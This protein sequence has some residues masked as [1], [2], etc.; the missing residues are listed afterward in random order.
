LPGT[1]AAGAAAE[2]QSHCNSCGI[3]V[4]DI[5]RIRCA[6]CEDVDLCADCF[7]EGKE[8]D[9]HA[10]DHPYRV[11]VRSAFPAPAR[12]LGYRLT[13]VWAGPTRTCWTIPCWTRRG[14]RTRS[15]GC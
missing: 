1:S 3:D 12:L 11:V 15:C 9:G 10:N 14:A 2:Q 13:R 8:P 4:T 7:A 5:V 6:T